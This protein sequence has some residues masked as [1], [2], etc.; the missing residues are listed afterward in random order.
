MIQTRD[1][2]AHSHSHSQP[3][4]TN[5]WYS[6]PDR[7]NDYKVLSPLPIHQIH[8]G[9]ALRRS[10]SECVNSVQHQRHMS[11]L[12]C[13]NT[14]TSHTSVSLTVE[15]QTFEFQIF[16]VSALGLWG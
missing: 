11:A 5:P 3:H 13:V 10:C 1:K 8:I 15:L 14:C 4:D 6:M 7:R 12:I 16:D 9:S 2:A